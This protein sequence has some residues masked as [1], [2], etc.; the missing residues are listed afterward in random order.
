MTLSFQ[1]FA[2]T[3]GLMADEDVL[4][5][6]QRWQAEGQRVALVTLAGVEGGAPRQAG[7]QMA[8]AQDGR[9]AGYLSGGC[10]EAAVVHEAQA[11]LADGRN[12]LVRYGKGSPYFDIKLP[13]G[14]GLDL[15]FDQDL[16]PALVSSMMDLRA[17]RQPFALEID[18]KSGA[19]IARAWAQGSVI[20]QSQ[21]DG[22]T[23]TRVYPPSLRLILL[24]NG[25]ALT[26]MAA[27]AAT[28][29]IDMVAVSTDDATRAALAASRPRLE[30]AD[31]LAGV[32][33]EPDF[34]TAAVLFLHEHDKEPDILARLLKTPCF[35][36]GALGNHAVHRTRIAMLEMRGFT[37]AELQ[38]IRAPV[39]AIAGA[40]S[41]ATL[42]VGIFAE[43]LA[44]AKAHNLVS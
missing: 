10:L 44:E 6:V 17:R 25:P 3:A 31:T 33:A 5:Q 1:N 32:N 11:V 21:R 23:F 15:Y 16:D 4:S 28:L 37:K 34:A 27:L 19:K 38:R 36:I 41:K 14:S 40:K 35:Y 42:A 22:D 43:I 29:G 7:D 24:G 13:C 8:V 30:V 2:P 39:G 12:R 9:F 20:P 26:G 18:L